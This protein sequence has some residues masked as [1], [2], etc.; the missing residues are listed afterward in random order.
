M[1]SSIV[2]KLAA[3]VGIP[4]TR[5][6]ANH[7]WTFDGATI[8]D[9]WVS[10]RRD[11]VPYTDHDIL[12]EIGHFL[13]AAPEQRDLPEFGLFPI[14]RY[15]EGIGSTSPDYDGLVDQHEQSAQEIVTQFLA[16]RMG[17]ALGVSPILSEYPEWCITW[18]E[19]EK[20]KHKEGQETFSDAYPVALER[21]PHLLA[22]VDRMLATV[23]GGAC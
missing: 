9:Y 7:T 15:C 19:Y 12:H 17:R 4:V 13:A 1:I 5:R 23:V 18:D 3:S 16:L 6:C 14:N 22:Q 21:L 8:A 10:E 11:V 20:F 2:R